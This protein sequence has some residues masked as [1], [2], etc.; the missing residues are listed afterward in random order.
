VPPRQHLLA[1]IQHTDG[2]LGCPS[3]AANCISDAMLCR[4]HVFKARLAVDDEIAVPIIGG[5]FLAKHY[6][7]GVLRSLHR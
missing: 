4:G 5:G 6:I 7:G 2:F 1:I 3:P